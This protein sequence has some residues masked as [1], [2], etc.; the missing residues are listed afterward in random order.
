MTPR[1]LA[2]RSPPRNA[3]HVY[4]LDEDRAGRGHARAASNGPRT[5]DILKTATK[6]RRHYSMPQPRRHRRGPKPDRRRVLELLAA[7]RDGCTEADM[8][9]HGFTVPQMVELV[10]A[11]ACERDGRARGR[12]R[13]PRRDDAGEDHGG[14]TSTLAQS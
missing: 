4:R 10:R 9:A 11:R 7:S 2:W 13:P 5:P 12:A 1:S 14:G 8:L 6:H 3:G